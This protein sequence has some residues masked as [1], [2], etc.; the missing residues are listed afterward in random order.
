MPTLSNFFQKTLSVLKMDWSDLTNELASL[1]DNNS[2][3]Q[4]HIAQVYDRIK[5]LAT[6]N[7]T[8]ELRYN[9]LPMKEAIV[10]ET[11]ELTGT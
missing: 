2:A 3:N 8:G 1:R 5:R 4:A 10:V 9:A 11:C 7:Q 6:A